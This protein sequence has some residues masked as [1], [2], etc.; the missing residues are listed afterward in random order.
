[1]SNIAQTK[2]A[3]E[4]AIALYPTLKA[5]SEEIGET[6]QVVQQWK[7]NGVPPEKC[8]AVERASHGVTTRK[9]LRPDDWESIWPELKQ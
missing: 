1:M 7:I 5:F 4:R 8:V 6:Y 2:E 3:L 9:D